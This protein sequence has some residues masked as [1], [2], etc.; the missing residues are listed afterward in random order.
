[1]MQTV[2]SVS[3]TLWLAL[4]FPS[5]ADAATVITGIVRTESGQPL[6]GLALL[7]KGELHNNR[8]DH[9]TLVE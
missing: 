8:W 6:P 7:E 1:M 3:L 9:G 5:G 2:V 4:A